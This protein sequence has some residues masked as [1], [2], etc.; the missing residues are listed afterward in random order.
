MNIA[1]GVLMLFACLVNIVAAAFYSGVG[2]LF[3]LLTFV[4]AADGGIRNSQDGQ[5]AEAALTASGVVI[6]FAVFLGL[7][8][9]LQVI[10]CGLLFAERA[11]KYIIG[12]AVLEIL[13]CVTV[14]LTRGLGF[15]TLFGLVVAGLAI[16]AAKS[17]IDDVAVAVPLAGPPPRQ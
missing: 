13:A 2:A 9:L 14:V 12:V 17:M 7:L 1:A 10:A 16:M 4:A 15:W 6:M 5:A 8:A 3:G 11:P